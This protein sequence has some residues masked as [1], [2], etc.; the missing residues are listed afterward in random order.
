M[1]S[2]TTRV[3]EVIGTTFNHETGKIEGFYRKTRLK[4][5]KERF[6]DARLTS[7]IPTYKR[8]AL[9][10]IAEAY[11]RAIKSKNKVKG[12]LAWKQKCLLQK[13]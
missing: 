7:S 3:K 2:A 10:E 11:Q 8:R 9:I 5:F 1:K 13:H 12:R 4:T 6:G